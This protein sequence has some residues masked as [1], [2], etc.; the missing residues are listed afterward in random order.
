MTRQR[1]LIHNN[2]KSA[3][4]RAELRRNLTPAEAFLWKNLQNRKLEGKKFRRQH[5]IGPYTVDFYCPEFRVAVELDGAGHMTPIGSE[6]DKKR[7]EFLKR[8]NVRVIRF[9]NQWVFKNLEAVLD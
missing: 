4:H 6:E 9:E 8:F 5:A 2:P 3:Q 7:D 1:G